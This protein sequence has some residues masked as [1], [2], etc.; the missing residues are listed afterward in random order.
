ME[1]WEKELKEYLERAEK[2]KHVSDRYL[3][4]IQNA[5]R[6]AKLAAAQTGKKDSEQTKA[7][8]RASRGTRG[9]KHS[10]ETK[11]KIS[12]LKKG[13]PAPN[14]GIPHSE[15]ARLKMSMNSGNKGKPAHNKG[16]PSP[17]KGVPKPKLMCPHCNLV[18]GS[19][20][21]KRWHF[22]NCKF[23]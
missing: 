4:G 17:N 5:E 21:V 16:K 9:I 14:K 2:K 23:K 3:I 8:K 18:G 11:L 22:D 15:E 1:D 12:A 10:E 6:K 13:S 19:S 20:Q 7:K